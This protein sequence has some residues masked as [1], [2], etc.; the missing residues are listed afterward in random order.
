M[1]QT[2]IFN[3]VI[4]TIY[5]D[6]YSHIDFMD[7]MGGDCDCIIHTVLN[8]LHEYEIDNG[9]N[10]ALDYAEEMQMMEIA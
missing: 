6:N 9:P 3:K 7:N 4:H 8:F 1:T 10:E 2:E 5:N